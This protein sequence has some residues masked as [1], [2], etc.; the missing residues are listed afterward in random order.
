MAEKNLLF[1]G[2]NLQVLREEIT[3]ESVDLV[4]L[5]PPFN[6]NRSYNVLFTSKSG[7]E[8]HAQIEAFDDTWMWSQEAEAEYREMLSGRVPAKVADAIIA[9]RGLLGEN[10]VLAYLV[11]MTPR[12]VELH[13]V[14]K[15][16][17]SLY[18]HCDPTA[19]HYLKLMLDAVFGPTSFVN[20]ITWKRSSA[21]SDAKQGSKHYGRISDTILFYSKSNQRVWNQLYGPYD[22]EYINRDYRRV[23]EYGRRYRISDL[24]GPGGAAKGNPCYEFLGVTRHWRYGKERMEQLLAEGRIVQTKP[25]AVPQYK[26]YLD[27]MPGIPLQNVWTDVPVINNRSRE[28]LHYPTQKP[29]A[30]LERLISVSSNE[31]DLILDPFCGCGTTVAVAQRLRR[32]WIGVDITYLAVD[33]ITK[34]L[35]NRYGEEVA[36][37]FDVRGIPRDLEGA[38]ALF[39]ENS[40][41][42][43]RWAVSLVG[44]E[45]N[46]KQVGDKGID[47]TIRFHIDSKIIGRV[48]VSVKGGRKLNPGMVRDLIG[49][50]NSRRAEMGLL[51]TLEPPTRGMLE[52]VRRSGHYEYPLTQRSFPRIQLITISELLAGIQLAMPA[53]ILPYVRARRAPV[54]EQGKLKL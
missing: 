32:R 22:Q 2:D 40:F 5:D 50:V 52:E 3:S 30:L 44:G 41:D 19:S 48:L 51:I 47:G 24:S 17:G 29:E 12:L 9:L 43:E 33:L 14:L 20:E 18:L 42:F 53:S 39:K 21:H 10:D 38:R 8:A 49:T 36:D 23:D 7:E 16:T 26:R 15:P 1:Y 31:G 28:K 46:E 35:I 25:G 37:T 6:S 11:M 27:E 54:G 4:Y 34:R 13:R 45:P